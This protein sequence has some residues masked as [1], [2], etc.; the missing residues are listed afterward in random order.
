[1]PTNIPVEEIRKGFH[2][3]RNPSNH[4]TVLQL[5]Y[6]TDPK[7]DTLEWK[8]RTRAGYTWQEW[9]QEYEIVD[10]AFDGMP[11]YGEDFSY[12]FHVST[13]KKPEWNPEFPIVRGWD[14]GLAAEGMACVFTQLIPPS[15]VFVYHELTAS[16]LDVE[17]FV[18]EVKRM[19]NEWFPSATKF[20]DV[21]D[22]TCFNRNQLD[23]RRAAELI[24]DGLHTK[25][26]PGVV[27]IIDRRR[28]VTR[29]LKENRR[30][31]PA[32]V[33]ST[34]A[35]MVIEG[36]IGGYHYAFSKFGQLKT[37]PEKNEYSHIHDALQYVCTRILG[38][39]NGNK[40]GG[41]VIPSPKY[42]FSHPGVV[43]RQ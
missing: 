16:D 15:R 24:R 20:F 5:H 40:K 17:H 26:I 37:E 11:V 1:M 31:M 19:S 4:F 43:V 9:L 36:F 21:V 6:S 18:P 33:I 13:D 28:A 34:D 38:L 23:K 35:K 12:D 27:S 22:P 29:F 8:E 25:P 32:M 39:D 30:G 42:N 41:L 3:W 7:K 10:S 14:V 2:V